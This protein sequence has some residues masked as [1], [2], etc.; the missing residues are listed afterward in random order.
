MKSEEVEVQAVQVMV[1]L[2]VNPGEHRQG[3]RN[4]LNQLQR[5]DFIQPQVIQ[6]TKDSEAG[7]H[8]QNYHARGETQSQLAPGTRAF[9]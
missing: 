6:R 2:L 8:G 3:G 9:E 1:V 7:S 5:P 4:L